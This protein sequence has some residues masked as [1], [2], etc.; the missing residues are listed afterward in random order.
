MRQKILR[1]NKLG[2]WGVR[3]ETANVHIWWKI[4]DTLTLTKRDKLSKPTSF[5]LL[6][7]RYA[8]VPKVLASVRQGGN[9][10]SQD[11]MNMWLEDLTEDHF[12]VCLREVKTFDGKHVNLKVVSTFFCRWAR[13]EILKDRYQEIIL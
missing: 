13:W 9:S 2:S 7:Q 12:R 8:S 10:R 5:F 6:L 3:D 1:G 11:A 4:K